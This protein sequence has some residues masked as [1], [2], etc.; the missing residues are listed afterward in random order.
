M[1]KL[2]IERMLQFPVLDPKAQTVDVLARECPKLNVTLLS[3]SLPHNV[4]SCA[5]GLA[6]L[7]W[8]RLLLQPA[9]FGVLLVQGP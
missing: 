3:K 2:R 8:A 4:E 5:I 1:I 7:G 9:L 6:F